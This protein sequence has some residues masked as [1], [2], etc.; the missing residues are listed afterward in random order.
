MN[1]YAD[2][3]DGWFEGLWIEGKTAHFF[4][5]NYV[6]ERFVIVASGVAELAVDG[7]KSGNIIYDVLIR[8]W[9]E[10]NIGDIRA[11]YSL[12]GSPH[13]EA[14]TNRLKEKVQLEQWKLLEMNS[15]YG[16]TGLVLAGSFELLHRELWLE[17][18]STTKTSIPETP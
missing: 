2:F 15:S 9:Q 3:H 7:V 12:A 17:R 18:Y 1:E 11:L 8:D 4:V 5:A 16:A 10:V 13:E 14:Q 6:P